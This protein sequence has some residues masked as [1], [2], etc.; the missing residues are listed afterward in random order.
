MHNIIV[1]TATVLACFVVPFFAFIWPVV[2]K[3]P[4][5]ILVRWAVVGLIGWAILAI[6]GKMYQAAW[7]QEERTTGGVPA[8]DPAFTMMC[9]CLLYTSP[10]PRD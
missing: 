2:P 5:S 10:S 6:S 3:N 8:W 4:N 1:N 7:F 9:F